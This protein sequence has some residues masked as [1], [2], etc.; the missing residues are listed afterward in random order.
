MLSETMLKL[1]EQEFIHREIGT[2]IAPVGRRA[3]PPAASL[4]N[5]SAYSSVGSGK[6]FKGRGDCDLRSSHEEIQSI[7]HAQQ[8]DAT[9]ISIVATG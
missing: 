8:P 7:Y 9:R 1:T 6:T 5:S 4:D 2:N 3:I